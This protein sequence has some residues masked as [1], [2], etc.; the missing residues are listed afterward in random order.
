METI[1]RNRRETPSFPRLSESY[2]PN[3]ERVKDS[4]NW[5]L[6]EL[7]VKMKTKVSVFASLFNLL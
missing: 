6:E 7:K 3:N 5:E 1:H 2:T 4:G